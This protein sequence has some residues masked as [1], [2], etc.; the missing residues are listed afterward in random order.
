MHWHMTSFKHSPDFH[1]ERLAARIALVG[2]NTGTLAS[3][4]RN[5][6][7]RAAMRAN[8][9]VR[10]HDTLDCIARFVLGKG[11]DLVEGQHG[12]CLSISTHKIET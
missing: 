10:P 7:D 12:A 1:G 4:L 2:A 11:G 6:F 3:H 8:R 5:A 9:A